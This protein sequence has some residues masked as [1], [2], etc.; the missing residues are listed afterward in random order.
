MNDEIRCLVVK[1]GVTTRYINSKMVVE[2]Y[3]EE[4]E[5][6]A[7][8]YISLS[9]KPEPICIG[10]LAY[11]R[12]TRKSTN[13]ALALANG[14]ATIVSAFALTDCDV[15]RRRAIFEML[16]IPYD[17]KEEAGKEDFA[18]ESTTLYTAD[19]L[20]YLTQFIEKMQ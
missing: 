14:M 15:I 8:V 6:Y 3:A 1:T 9:G 17:E 11:G 20:V 16:G 13:K 5:T 7:A 10:K 12:K 4:K 2:V 19:L 18:F